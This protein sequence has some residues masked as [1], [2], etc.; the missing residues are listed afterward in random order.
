MELIGRVDHYWVYLIEIGL[1]GAG[2]IQLKIENDISGLSG[3]NK[4]IS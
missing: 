1:M 3:P 4:G 2:S